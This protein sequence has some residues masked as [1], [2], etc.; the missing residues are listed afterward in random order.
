[1]RNMAVMVIISLFVVD[2]VFAGSAPH[3]HTNDNKPGG[4]PKKEAHQG[5]S[6][7]VRN[8][9]DHSVLDELLFGKNDLSYNIAYEYHEFGAYWNVVLDFAPHISGTNSVDSILTPQINLIMEDRCYRG[10]VGIL[11]SYMMGQDDDWTDIYWQFI[12]GLHFRL[13]KKI[14][15][16]LDTLYVF[17]NWDELKEFDSGDIEYGL[18]IGVAL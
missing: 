3:F 8:H 15:L 18:S 13:S 6:V 11:K 10:G 17:G 1:M 2:P 4:A 12:L 9:I 5:F 14:G 7:G 16:D